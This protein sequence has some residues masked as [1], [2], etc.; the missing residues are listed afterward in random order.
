MFKYTLAILTVSLAS[1][2]AAPVLAQSADVSPT[3]LIESGPADNPEYRRMIYVKYITGNRVSVAYKAYNRTEFAQIT[4]NTA[5]DAI[6]A[7]SN[8]PA[9]SLGDILAFERKEAGL[10]R[11]RQAPEVTR[12]CIKNVNNW[13]GGG[14]T[15]YLDPIFNSMPYAATLN[16]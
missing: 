2:H 11:A 8:G 13:E 6:L 15:R 5:P 9:T 3:L 16:N 14:R 7:C 10:K 12:F 4:D 1:V